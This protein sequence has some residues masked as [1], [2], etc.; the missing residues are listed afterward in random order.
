MILC[1]LSFSNYKLVQAMNLRFQ[2]TD[3]MK[4]VLMIKQPE[5][6]F[7][8][9]HIRLCPFIFEPQQDKQDEALMIMMINNTTHKQKIQKKK[10]K[11]AKST[12]T[13]AN[14]VI[15]ANIAPVCSSSSK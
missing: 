8:F 13:Q 14:C 15:H 3:V 6:P 2:T 9:L 5:K 1:K 11:K 4:H 7:Y 12:C 10:K